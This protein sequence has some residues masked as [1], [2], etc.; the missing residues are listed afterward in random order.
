MADLH[1][2]A[3]QH[4]R[5]CTDERHRRN[6]IDLQER[7]RH[8]DR[9]RVNARGNR[10]RQHGH[11]AERIA[12]A[13]VIVLARLAHHVCAN[14]PQQ[15]EGDPVINACDERLKTHAECIADERHQK[16]KAAEIQSADD[17]V[18]SLERA[19]AQSL[20]DRHRERVHRQTDCD[21]KQLQ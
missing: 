16:L 7:K 8:A 9:K 13:F 19:H 10:K 12:D 3:R 2:D 11:K 1:A 6:D 17:R 14:K 15:H 5:G 20:A 21:Q 4:K 18:L